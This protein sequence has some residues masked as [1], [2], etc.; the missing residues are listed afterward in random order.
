MKIIRKTY[1]KCKKFSG[2]AQP[3]FGN[4]NGT[5]EVVFLIQSY[6]NINIDV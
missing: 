2:N 4:G 5:D 1:K 3:D 6:C